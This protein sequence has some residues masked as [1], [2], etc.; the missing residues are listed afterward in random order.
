MGH[1]FCEA[2]IEYSKL[3]EP[4]RRQYVQ[5]IEDL[6]Q[7]MDKK[8]NEEAELNA[9]LQA[10]AENKL[11]MGDGLGTIYDENDSNQDSDFSGEDDN[12]IK[13]MPPL[14]ENSDDCGAEDNKVPAE[15]EAVKPK[16][17]E[18]EVNKEKVK[19]KKGDA[20]KKKK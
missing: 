16:E 20:K 5:E 1:H 4:T 9:Q 13:E 10:N 6:I 19:K 11:Q 12:A 7:N 14:A 3:E 2:I 15:E 18:P 17:S 8:P